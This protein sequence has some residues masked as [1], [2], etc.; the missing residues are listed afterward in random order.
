MLTKQY[1]YTRVASE[2]LQVG[3]E[4]YDAR[5]LANSVGGRAVLFTRIA[6]VDI[7]GCVKN[8][9]FGDRCYALIRNGVLVVKVTEK[10]ALTFD[11]LKIGEFF[12]LRSKLYCQSTMAFI[13]VSHN[14]V[15]VYSHSPDGRGWDYV[16]VEWMSYATEVERL[17][18]LPDL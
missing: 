11:D 1:D 2:S 7:D 6:P 4:F 13:K 3:D 15:A 5:S 12:K 16:E 10:K 8:A 17:E 9:T 14:T 18:K